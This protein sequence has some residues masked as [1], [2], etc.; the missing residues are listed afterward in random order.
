MHIK[1][2]SKSKNTYNDLLQRNSQKYE[3]PLK[4]EKETLP[5]FEEI[6]KIKLEEYSKIKNVSKDFTNQDIEKEER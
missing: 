6:L 4:R 2:V 3:K 5:S 1:K